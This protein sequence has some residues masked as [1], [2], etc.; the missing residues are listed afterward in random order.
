MRKR[1]YISHPDSHVPAVYVTSDDRLVH[2]VQMDCAEAET[3]KPFHTWSKTEAEDIAL[4]FAAF[5]AV[6]ASYNAPL[7]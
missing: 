1:Y 7:Q 6:V 5:G 4:S 2:D 3:A